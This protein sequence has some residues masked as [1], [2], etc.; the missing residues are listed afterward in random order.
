MRSMFVRSRHALVVGLMSLASGW[1]AATLGPIPTTLKGV[2]VPSVPGLYDGANPI[3]VNKDKAIALGKALFWDSHVGSDGMACASCHF[4]AGADRRTRN[5]WAPAAKGRTGSFDVGSDGRRRGPNL[6][7]KLS[8]FPLVQSGSPLT[9]TE[10]AG[11]ARWSDD[12]VGSAGAFGGR[13]KGVD[14]DANPHDDCVRTADTTFQV[15]GTG[16]RRVIER[17]APTVINAAFNHRQLWDGRANNLFNGSSAWGSRDPLAGIWVLQADGKVV[18]ERLALPNSALASQAMTAPLNDREMSCQGRA[19]A[20]LGRK[21]LFRTPLLDQAVHPQDSVL[22]A[23]SAAPNKGLQGSYME[24]V[25]QAFHPRFWSHVKRGAFGKPAVTGNPVMRQP[26]S[27]AEAN[28]SLFFGLALQ[29]Y[30]STLVSDDSPFDRSARDANN[31]P[32]DLTASQLRGLQVFRRAHCSLC[33]TGPN[34]T[35]SAIETNAQLVSSRPWAFGDGQFPN[36]TTHNVVTR[37]A[38][39][40]GFGLIDTGFAATGVGKDE[41]DV[42][43]AGKDDLGNDLSYASQFL[44]LLAGN[45]AAVKDPQVLLVRPC[46]LANPIAYD[47]PKAN[48]NFFTQAEG[49]QAQLHSTTGCIKPAGAF[50]PT[51]A[52]AKAELAKATNKRMLVITDSA[53]KIPTLRNIEL[54]GPFMH[55]GSMATLDQVIEFYARGGNFHGASKQFGTVFSQPELQVDAQARADLKAFLESLTDERVRHERAPFD[56]PE[57]KVPHGHAGNASA[58]RGSSVWPGLADDEFITVPAVGAQGRST[59]LQPF[60]SFLAP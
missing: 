5:Q 28:F 29:A 47:R 37:L 43:L 17:N 41:W 6:E 46:D 35:A 49:V 23:L 24:L 10:V 40:K 31:L 27:Q 25:K 9:E 30:Q 4:H 22:G 56:H 19:M 59:P 20:D 21:L 11:I 58:V 52:A 1:A 13:F 44:Q 53:F 39:T 2:A 3:I 12:V 7:L 16:V 38:G 55:N 18:K 60:P 26:Y 54:T 42:G 45:A 8:E 57:L 34:F 48:A 33:H 15:G 51:V 36:T 50:V 14:Y 32:T